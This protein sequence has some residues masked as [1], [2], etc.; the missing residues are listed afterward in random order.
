MAGRAMPKHLEARSISA[1]R[2]TAVLSTRYNFT[3]QLLRGAAIFTHRARELDQP[4]ISEKEQAEHLAAALETEIYSIAK[5]GPGH[6][7]GSNNIA[8]AGRQLLFPSA[9]EI[10]RQETLPRYNSVLQLLKKHAFDKGR[11]PYQDAD[12]LVKLRN[13]L[14]HF[15]SEWGEELDQK[16]ILKGLKSLKF[17]KPSFV[18]LSTNFFPLQCL[19]ASLASWAVTTGV[20]FIDECYRKLEVP[21]PLDDHKTNLKVHKP[22]KI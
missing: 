16:D 18:D 21:S 2:S 12:L 6:H 13:E 11:N 9:D 20:N 7:L 3:A 1:V 10:D 19:S 15:K 17:D 5:Y 4:K 8:D 14:I 22:R